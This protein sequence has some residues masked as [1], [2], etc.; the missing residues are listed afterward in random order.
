M[1]IKYDL[2]ERSVFDLFGAGNGQD[3]PEI[4]QILSFHTTSVGSRSSL[5]YQPVVRANFQSYDR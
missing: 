4:D 2:V 3:T 5:K 1:P